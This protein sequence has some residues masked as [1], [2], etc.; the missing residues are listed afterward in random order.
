MKA[1]KKILLIFTIF[2]HILFSTAF[3]KE[4]DNYK[5]L[6]SLTS[7]KN[8]IDLE[9]GVE[10]KEYNAFVLER[11]NNGLILSDELKNIV[12]IEIDS[13]NLWHY[14]KGDYI[15]FFID[16][17]RKENDIYIAT[18]TKITDHKSENINIH[19]TKLN[20]KDIKLKGIEYIEFEN[21]VIENSSIKDTEHKIKVYKNFSI[22]PYLDG[23]YQR[24]KGFLIRKND[25][26]LYFYVT[27]EEKNI[28]PI[29]ITKENL[30][31]INS[32]YISSTSTISSIPFKYQELG[33]YGYG[34]QMR[35]K[36][37]SSNNLSSRLYN[38]S[39]FEAPIKSITLTYSN[40]K[41][42]R[43]ANHVLEITLKDKNTTKKASIFLNTKEETYTYKI[44]P[45]SSYYFIDIAISDT[46]SYS[47][48][49]ESII[50]ELDY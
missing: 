3:I 26:E 48:F 17:A 23:I 1:I 14:L 6:F 8:D 28:N 13:H 32:K 25:I 47:C 29:I 18:C 36:T 7:L 45:K 39:P 43:D 9:R 10:G 16:D 37:N 46:Y 33:F 35:S 50:I 41:K 4:A 44:I 30:N 12:L 31:L 15:S 24:L 21:V 20:I 42:P 34:I 22:T 2:S 49:F 11:Y 27:I 5:N 38:E 19:P 40:L